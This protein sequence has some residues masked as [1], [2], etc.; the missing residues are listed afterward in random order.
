MARLWS[1]KNW[2]DSSRVEE[3][4]FSSLPPPFPSA[5]VFYFTEV[6]KQFFSKFVTSTVRRFFVKSIERYFLQE[7]ILNENIWRWLMPLS[8]SIELG[9]LG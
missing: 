8:I 4:N 9:C 3:D 2:T 1:Q 5:L 6:S 7:H